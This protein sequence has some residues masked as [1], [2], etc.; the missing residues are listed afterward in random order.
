[1]LQL[2]EATESRTSETTRR[3]LHAPASVTGLGLPNF[4]VDQPVMHNMVMSCEQWP[5]AAPNKGADAELRKAIRK[6][7]EAL[8]QEKMPFSKV[9]QETHEDQ[10]DWLHIK[11]IHRN[12]KINDTAWA[13]ALRDRLDIYDTKLLL[14]KCG[15]A[16]NTRDHYQCCQK[17]AGGWWTLRHTVVQ[18]AFRQAARSTAIITSAGFK[19]IYDVENWNEVPDLIVFDGAEKPTVIDFSV[20]H[21]SPTFEKE[22]RK[23]TTKR[24]EEKRNTYKKW[25]ADT[26]LVV[27]LV[28]TTRFTVSTEGTKVIQKIAD[29]TGRPNFTLEAKAQMKTALINFE[30]F[31]ARRTRVHADPPHVPVVT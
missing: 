27:P 26:A 19:T 11:N 24:E 29:N 30:D 28:L 13:T 14:D 8:K 25:N 17:C 9:W 7:N 20:C 21:Q 22:K 5:P 18:E 6:S 12:L 2:A 1:M 3:L 23:A 31:R 4:V 16:V 10:H 15:R